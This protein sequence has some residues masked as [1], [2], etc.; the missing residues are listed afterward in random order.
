[1]PPILRDTVNNRAVRILLECILVLMQ[2]KWSKIY[3]LIQMLSRCLIDWAGGI[4]FDHL[5]LL[6]PPAS[7]TPE[8]ELL[9]EN[10]QRLRCIPQGCYVF[11]LIISLSLMLLVLVRS[12]VL[13]TDTT[14]NFF[15]TYCPQ[16]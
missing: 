14:L 2:K 7:H 16:T 9:R 13:R 15:Y 5:N 8:S 1:M 10:L 3:I 11:W 12:K 4:C 6:P